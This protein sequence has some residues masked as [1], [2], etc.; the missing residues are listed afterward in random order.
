MMYIYP[1]GDPADLIS[2]NPKDQPNAQPLTDYGGS[3]DSDCGGTVFRNI[4][5]TKN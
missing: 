3:R 4:H 1:D 2:I 5:P